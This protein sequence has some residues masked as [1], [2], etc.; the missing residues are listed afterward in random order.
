MKL[1]LLSYPI[2]PHSFGVLNGVEQIVR[3]AVPAEPRLPV[4]TG[5][6]WLAFEHKRLTHNRRQPDDRYL[7]PSS[8]KYRVPPIRRFGYSIKAFLHWALRVKTESEVYSWSRCGSGT[9]ETTYVMPLLSCLSTNPY[10]NSTSTAGTQKTT[11]SF[12]KSPSH[13]RSRAATW[14]LDQLARNSATVGPDISTVWVATLA[15][16]SSPPILA[17]VFS[18]DARCS[19]PKSMGPSSYTY[20]VIV[21]PRSVVRQ[22]YPTAMGVSA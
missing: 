13:P 4:A 6:I 5:L 15:L 7:H 2:T 20:Q 22:S 3:H 19:Q 16:A 11:G 12:R 10:V 1:A 18:T 8:R 21:T 9:G 17:A 14:A